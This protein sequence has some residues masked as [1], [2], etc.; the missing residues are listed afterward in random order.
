MCTEICRNPPPQSLNRDLIIQSLSQANISP[1]LRKNTE[2]T[3][4]VSFIHDNTVT[5]PNNTSLSCLGKI[6][7]PFTRMKDGDLSPRL[8]ID[9]AAILYAALLELNPLSMKPSCLNGD[10]RHL[11]RQKHLHR[12]G[13]GFIWAHYPERSLPGPEQKTNAAWQNFVICHWELMSNCQLWEVT[14]REN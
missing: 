14:L 12:S 11:S 13:R 2:G 9:T 6:S 1:L 4:S 10:G 5:S 3:A 7:L 8:W